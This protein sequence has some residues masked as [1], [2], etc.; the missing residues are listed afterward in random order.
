MGNQLCDQDKLIVSLFDGKDV[1]YVGADSE[2]QQKLNHDSNSKNL[3]LILNTPMWVSDIISNCKKHLFSSTRTFYIGINRYQVLG[4]DTNTV[5]STTENCSVDLI[6]LLSTTV[7]EQGF[8]VKK[9][10]HFDHDLGR[11]FNFVQPLTWI[12]GH[13]VTN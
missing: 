6:C 2:F 10:G 4:N 9:S 12:Y 7:K 3:V 5:Y 13:N 1:N 11:Y 8:D